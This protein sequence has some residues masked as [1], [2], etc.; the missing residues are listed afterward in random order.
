MGEAKRR[1][2]TD[3]DYGK[4]AQSLPKAKK[5]G[6]SLGKFNFKKI[7]K[8]EMIIWAVLLGGTAATFIWTSTLQ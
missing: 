5:Q 4:K 1:K 6:F 3:P 7:S 2:A 8:T